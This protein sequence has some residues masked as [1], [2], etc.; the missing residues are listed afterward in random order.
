MMTKPM[1][2]AYPDPL[3]CNS[4]GI[5]GRW[6][7]NERGSRVVDVCRNFDAGAISGATWTGSKSGGGLRFD[8]S[9][10]YVNIGKRIQ[11]YVD[12]NKPF[13]IGAWFTFHTFS[14]S[15]TYSLFGAAHQHLGFFDQLELTINADKV[16]AILT[17]VGAGSSDGRIWD[18]TNSQGMGTSGK[19]FVA[20][21]YNGLNATNS[22]AFYFNGQNQAVTVTTNIGD[23]T[24]SI[25]QPSRLDKDIW[26]GRRNYS[27]GDQPFPGI[28]DQ[29]VIANR[30]WA[31]DE[32]KKMYQNPWSGLICSTYEMEELERA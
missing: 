23:I 19:Y 5:V 18:T 26:V 20:W 24:Q 15:G 8:G 29:I 25:W 14:G 21:V 3:H 9:D 10:D 30:I 2:G 27:T 6:L 4:M 11:R 7:F 32:V 22:T 13:S 31:A 1:C 12:Y 28:F 17:N 16:R